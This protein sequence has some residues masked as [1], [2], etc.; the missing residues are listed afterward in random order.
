VLRWIG[1]VVLAVALVPAMAR[2]V[3][4]DALDLGGDWQLRKLRFVGNRAVPA[5]SLRDSIVTKRRPWYALWRRWPTFDPITF[6]TDLERIARLYQSRGY[7]HARITHDIELPAEGHAVV[8]VVYLEEGEPVTVERVDVEL[9][10]REVTPEQ[11]GPLMALL[12]I[13]G[14]DVFSEEAYEKGAVYLRAWHRE[15]GYARVKVEKSAELDLE[16][17]TA[18]VS[19]RVDG[20]PVCTFGD[21]HIAGAPTV[22][23]D[24]VRRE[25]AFDPGDPF[26][27]SAL[28]RTRQNL[29]SL[30]LFRAVRLHEDQGRDDRVDLDVKVSEA[31]PHEIRLGLGYGTDDQVRGL[32][33]WRHYNFLGGAR[34]L[35]FTASAS[36]IE[37]TLAADFLQ[38]HF[39]GHDN[40]TRLIFTQSQDDEDGYDLLRTRI[41]PRLEWQ[42]THRVTGFVFHRTE[43]DEL[44]NVLPGL[45]KRLGDDA[46]SDGFLSG[47]GFGVDWDGTDDLLNPTRGFVTS[48]SIEP[49]GNFLGGDYSFV[50]GVWEGRLYFPIIRKLLGATRLRLGAAEPTDGSAEIPLF[51]RFFAGGINSVRGY[52]RRRVGPLVNDRPLGGRTLVETSVELRHPITE[53]L[54]GAVFLDGGQVSPSSFTFPF[55]H[56]RYGAGFGVRYKSPVGPLRLDIGFPFRPPDDDQFWQVHVSLGAAF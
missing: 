44:S 6:R 19:Y 4:L 52:G 55:G 54:G 12:P 33:S 18:L 31:P 13:A 45:R 38:P 23:E 51:E 14:G 11:R 2:A 26:K 27:Q 16:K 15:H 37:R 22:G 1:L 43:Y 49:V 3:Q 56:L 42:A 20:G 47:L 17:N 30:N 24:V 34:Q 46:V 41:T 10:E 48:A 21:V 29:M 50:R 8:A 5:G 40:R 35:G 25:L 32:A 7:Y 28:D 53:N 39:P 9:A 36:F